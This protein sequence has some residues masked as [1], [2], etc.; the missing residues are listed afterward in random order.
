MTV[1][2]R[3]RSQQ[4]ECPYNNPRKVTQAFVRGRNLRS[5]TAAEV[6]RMREIQHPREQLDMEQGYTRATGQQFEPAPISE[7]EIRE[8]GISWSED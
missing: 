3:N 4:G 5:M 1:V 7:F 6:I 8:L 2:I